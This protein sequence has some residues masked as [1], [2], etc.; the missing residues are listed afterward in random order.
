MTRYTVVWSQEALDLLAQIWISAD[1]K[2]EVTAASD[3]IDRELAVD[4]ESKGDLEG[5]R[6]RVLRIPPLRVT[7]SVHVD[8]RI[9]RVSLVKRT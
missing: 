8:D 6:I 5:E 2:Q 4:P 1:D 3:E 7:F 9:V